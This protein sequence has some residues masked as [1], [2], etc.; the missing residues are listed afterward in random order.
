MKTT[1]SH[2]APYSPSPNS[3]VIACGGFF[4][5][6]GVGTVGAGAGYRLESSF[7]RTTRAKIP[8]LIRWNLKSTAP[9]VFG[10]SETVW[11]EV[12]TSIAA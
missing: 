9:F 4:T 10:Q 2:V 3:L 12:S 1:G 11:S 6:E 7:Q 8:V 5:L